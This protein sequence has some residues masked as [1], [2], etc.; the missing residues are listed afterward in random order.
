MTHTRNSTGQVHGNAV[1]I[2]AATGG[3]HVYQGP[4]DPPPRHPSTSG[5]V[6]AH[7][8]W[9]FVMGWSLGDRLSLMP[10]HGS[11]SVTWRELVEAMSAV[12]FTE[13]DFAAASAATRQ[14]AEQL[15]PDRDRPL[16]QADRDAVVTTH[17]NAF[18]DLQRRIERRAD[19][20]E[21]MW[22]TIGHLTTDIRKSRTLHDK[23]YTEPTGRFSGPV[24]QSHNTLTRLAAA[25]DLPPTVQVMIELFL[26]AVAEEAELEEI[27]DRADAVHRACTAGLR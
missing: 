10:G 21:H 7:G 1:Q 19:H 9:Y 12:G 17:I 27:Y 2:G 18:H 23:G 8:P 26:A 25:A 13:A 11:Q 4:V 15:S 6:P 22:F 16:S 20:H 5:T 3:V 24:L 14:L